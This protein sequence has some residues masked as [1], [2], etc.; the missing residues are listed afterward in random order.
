MYTAYKKIDQALWKHFNEPEGDFEPYDSTQYAWVLGLQADAEHLAL[1]HGLE[2]VKEVVVELE[3]KFN[4]KVDLLDWTKIEKALEIRSDW[5]AALK[6]VRRGSDLSAKIGWGFEKSDLRTLLK[7]HQ[8]NKYR[9]KIE[10]LLTDCNF[11]SFCE[12]L[13]GGNYDEAKKIEKL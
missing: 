1:K 13:W 12:A 10:D 6:K 9:K 3:K 5:A 4:V 11:H 2:P 8:Q 7:L